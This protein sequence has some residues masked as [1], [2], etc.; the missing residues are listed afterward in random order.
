MAGDDDILRLAEPLRPR[1]VAIDAPLWLPAGMC[2]LEASCPCAARAADGLRA[3]E[4]HLL[5][6]GLG[7]Y[8]TTKRSIIKSMVYRGIGLRRLLEEAGLSVLEVYPY[9]SK[10]AL[11]GRPLPR[12]TT[13]AGRA[14]LRARLEPLI[15]GLAGLQR[16]LSH[17]ELDALVAAYT[18]LLVAE[19]KAE[20]VGSE[21]DGTIC[22]PRPAFAGPSQLVEAGGIC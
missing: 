8:R 16:R 10:V 5:R 7:L 21:E 9:A 12:K 6:R 14:F 11:F 19:G 2:C 17:D 15:P 13:S 1:F 22:L 20:R 3:A 18:A 4:R